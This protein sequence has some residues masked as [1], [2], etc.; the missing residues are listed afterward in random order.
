MKTYPIL[1]TTRL[2]LK[3]PT[4]DI[5]E[6]MTK[7]QQ[8][9][10]VSKNLSKVPY[11]YHL[12]DAQ[13]FINMCLENF[14]K[15]DGS[16]NFGVFLKDSGEFIG[17]CGLDLSTKH[18]HATLGYWF[19]KKYWG[20]GYATEAALKLVAYG[21]EQLELYR[22]ACGHFHTNPASG[23]VMKKVGLTHEGTRRGHFKKDGIY[24]DICDHGILKK[25]YYLIRESTMPLS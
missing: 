8:D 20:H 2:I 21:F 14:F 13:N 6:T 15:E 9:K 12:E 19:G 16:H 5:A 24:I 10:D 3:V 1:E 7:L 22:I 4:Q 11:P 17:M 23:H 25:E 18:N